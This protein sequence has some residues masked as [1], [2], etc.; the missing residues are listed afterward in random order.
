MP[1][2]TQLTLYNGAL[3]HI[4]E[5]PLASLSENREP[6]RNLDAVWDTGA[7]DTCLEQGQWRFAKRTVK[8]APETTIE[9]VFGYQFAYAH[10]ADFIRLVGISADERMSIP[11]TQYSV[12]AG[13]WFTDAS[14]LY[15]SYVSNDASYGDNFDL[16]SKAFE[17]YVEAY[18]ATRIVKRGTH[19]DE[20]LET[21]HELAKKLL[22]DA[23]SL[24]AIQSPTV[25][26]PTGSFVR[27]RSGGTR[28]DR[29]SR[30][31]LVG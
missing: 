10:P 3:G 2:P 30:D 22:N 5:R 27:A 17:R 14:P 1:A 24:D 18:L 20:D 29:G 8:L 28:G 12:E 26:P 15:V 9:P 7:V 23:K 25:F 6:R 19:S 21:L 31:Q 16:W 13:Y 4:G 11:M